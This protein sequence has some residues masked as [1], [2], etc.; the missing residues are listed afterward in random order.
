VLG[1]GYWL[2]ASQLLGKDFFLFIVFFLLE[3]VWFGLGLLVL[4]VQNRN[5]TEL[6]V[7]QK[8][9][10]GLIGFFSWFGFFG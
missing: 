5:Q 7:F 2:T 4:T 9:L 6:E 10:I 8:I 1:L 3:P